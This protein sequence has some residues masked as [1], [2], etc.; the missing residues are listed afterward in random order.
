[1]E[2]VRDKPYFELWKVFDTECMI[3]KLGDQEMHF[4]LEDLEE[5]KTEIRGWELRYYDD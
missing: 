5:L 3:L 1:M 4:H 2:D